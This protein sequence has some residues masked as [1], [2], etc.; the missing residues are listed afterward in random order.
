MPLLSQHLIAG[1]AG[2]ALPKFLHSVQAPHLQLH[3]NPAATIMHQAPKQGRGD[4][5]LG[6]SKVPLV[7][8]S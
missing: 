3:T 2:E 5:Q 7:I 8:T 4:Q 6:D 1:R